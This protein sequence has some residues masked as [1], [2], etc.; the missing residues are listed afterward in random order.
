MQFACAGAD[1]LRRGPYADPRSAWH[2]VFFGVYEVRVDAAAWDRPFAFE[3]ALPGAAP[4]GE[5]VVRL[6]KADWNDLSNGLYGVPRAV[7]APHDALGAAR[8]QEGAPET[9]EG[10][11]WRTVSFTNASAVSAWRN[12][13]DGARF[14]RDAGLVGVL[15]RLV[16]GTPAPGGPADR[17]SFAPTCHGGRFW[18]RWVPSRSRVTGRPCYRTLVAGAVVREDHPDDALRE[19]ILAAQS[20]ALRPFLVRASAWRGDP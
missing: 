10:V 1:L 5:D 9:I 19:R 15:W 11:E 8:W 4:R 6:G 3:T 12:P 20:R 18:L 14:D 17:Q 7:A 16:F 13:A 2:N